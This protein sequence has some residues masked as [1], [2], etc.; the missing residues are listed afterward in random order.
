MPGWVSPAFTLKAP[1]MITAVR[2]RLRKRF[3]KGFV[4][5][6]VVPALVSFSETPS[7]TPAKRSFS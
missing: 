4:R 5:A 1:T 6:I 2:P 7:F 3:I